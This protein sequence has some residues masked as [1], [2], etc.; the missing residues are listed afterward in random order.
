VA[1]AARLLHVRSELGYTD[2]PAQA[3]AYEPEAVTAAEQRALTAEARLRASQ[4]QRDAWRTF[5]EL[6]GP[7]LVALTVVLDRS[8]AADLRVLAR[9]LDRITRKLSA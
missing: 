2:R 5:V 6:V 7:E 4:L 3:L 1:D 9:Q 8:L